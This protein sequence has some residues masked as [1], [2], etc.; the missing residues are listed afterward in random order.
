M[1]VDARAGRYTVLV[2][3]DTG[4]G[5][6]PEIVNRIFDPFFTTKE[7]GKGSGL[8]LST[9][10]GILRSHG[11]FITVDTE[12]GRGTV[13]KSY[14]PAA[15]DTALSALIKTN[16]PAPKG[17]GELVLVVDDE[18]AI[19]ETTR[20]IL[21]H[22]QYR[23]ITA[24]DGR[25]ALDIYM[26]E[27]DNVRIVITDMMM[28]VMSGAALVRAL[29]AIEPRL[30]IIACSG[31]DQEAKRGEMAALGVAE[32]IMKPFVASQLL[33]MLRRHLASEHSVVPWERS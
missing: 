19:R 28:P 27:R 10:V 14:L 18:L 6:P 3:S 23:V 22:H 9:V 32:V 17:K 21:E 12:P 15:A 31:L 29:R 24:C 7:I 16:A 30:K 13:F 4:H 33:A 1:H 2:V 25:E 20:E 8:G 5:I 26:R 11:G